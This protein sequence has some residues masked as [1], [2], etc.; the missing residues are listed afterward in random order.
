[1]EVFFCERASKAKKFFFLFFP[2]FKVLPAREIA[3]SL[4]WELFSVGIKVNGRIFTVAALF[5]FFFVFFPDAVVKETES[6]SRISGCVGVAMALKAGQGNQ[7]FGPVGR[8][9]LSRLRCEILNAESFPI[10]CF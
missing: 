9:L 8:V 10:N 2:F 1:M 4:A 7:L 5:F 3:H 6:G